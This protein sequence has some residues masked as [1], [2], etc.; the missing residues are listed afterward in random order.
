MLGIETSADS[1]IIQP[2]E[3]IIRTPST[4]TTRNMN[5]L[6]QMCRSLPELQVNETIRLMGGSS[7]PRV[8]DGGQLLEMRD[9]YPATLRDGL[10][11]QKP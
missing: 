9:V 4:A 1:A 7:S 6:R 3:R 8:W 2:Y 11:M 5:S 10:P